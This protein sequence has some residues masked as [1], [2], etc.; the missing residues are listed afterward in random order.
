MLPC[1]G[2]AL[3]GRRVRTRRPADPGPPPARPGRHPLP[4][5][6][7]EGLIALQSAER[8]QAASAHPGRGPPLEATGA[9]VCVCSE[10]PLGHLGDRRT[11]TAGASTL[12]GRHDRVRGGLRP[13]VGR[14]IGRFQRPSARPRTPSTAATNGL[15]PAS[16]GPTPGWTPRTA[17]V[18]W[19]TSSSRPEPAR[20]W[21][22]GA[23]MTSLKDA[24]SRPGPTTRSRGWPTPTSSACCCARCSPR[25]AAGTG[26]GRSTTGSWPSNGAPPC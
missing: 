15:V 20:R 9:P 24:Q 4:A 2:V 14:L 21:C 13:S 18:G 12:P 3:D 1:A 16:A 10:S 17:V 5:C 23:G 8:L 7:L 25:P 22:Q 19:S 26:T 6:S 11:S